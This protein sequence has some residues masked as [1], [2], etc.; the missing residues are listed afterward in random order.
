MVSGDNAVTAF[1]V[2][3]FI[4]LGCLNWA[5]VAKPINFW[6]KGTTIFGATFGI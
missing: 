2:F 5:I 6:D 3:G 4:G 1:K